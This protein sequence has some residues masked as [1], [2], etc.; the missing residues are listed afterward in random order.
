[1]AY[2]QMDYPNE[3]LKQKMRQWGFGTKEDSVPNV[4]LELLLTNYMRGLNVR[5]DT[6]DPHEEIDELKRR[7]GEL[8]R[9]VGRRRIPTKADHVYELFKEELEKEQFGKIVAIDIESK[10]IVGIGNSILEA[11]N[12][13]REKTRKEQ[14]DFRRVGYKYVHKV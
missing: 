9:K 4:L 6:R 7:V 2:E 10:Q 13:A 11:Y 3:I 1:M 14:F 8:E 5:S 12:D